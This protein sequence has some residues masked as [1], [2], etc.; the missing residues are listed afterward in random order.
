MAAVVILDALSECA[1]ETVTDPLADM[2]PAN[3]KWSAR[4]PDRAHPRGYHE[5]FAVPECSGNTVL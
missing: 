4:V 5:D 3:E 1:A 2:A